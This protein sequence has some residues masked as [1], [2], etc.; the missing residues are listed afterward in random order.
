MFDDPVTAQLVDFVRGLG[1]PVQV[2][3]LAEDTFLPGLDI[4]DGALLIDP[5]RL[6][7]PGDILHE[8]GHI[9]VADEPRRLA[10]K[11][12]PTK[13]EEMAAIAWSF[14]AARHLGLPGEIVFHAAGYQGGSDN[15]VEAFTDGRGP[16]IPLLAWMGLTAEPHRA[17][18]TGLAAYPDMHRWIR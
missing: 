11:L 13:G 14:A 8:A 9:A 15:M 16:G 12:K 17:A 5:D 1:I 7:Y 4:R 10:Q 18:E 6:Q 2:T 3:D